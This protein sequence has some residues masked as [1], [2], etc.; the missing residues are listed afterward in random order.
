MFFEL[1]DIQRRHSAYWDVYNA[2]SYT[3]TPDN[4][5]SWNYQRGVMAGLLGCM[6]NETATIFRENGR[7]LLKHYERPA[8]LNQTWVFLKEAWKMSTL[9]NGLRNRLQYAT[10]MGV[11]DVANRIA[12]WRYFNAGYH[13]TQGQVETNVV[14]KILPSMAA[15][16]L[17]SWLGVPFEMA[18][19][20]FYADKTFP[21]ELQRGYTSYFNAL[22]RIPFEEGGYYLF[23]NTFPFIARNFF[24]T[25]TMFFSYDFLKDKLGGV[26]YRLTNNWPVDLTKFMAI[27]LTTY[28]S[29]VFSFFWGNTIR[30]AVD[31]WPK[32]KG[33]KCTFQGNYR[34]AA[35]WLWYHD[36]SSN[37]FPGFMN[38]YFWRQA[39]WMF[40]T[41]WTADTFGIFNYWRMDPYSGAGSNTWEDVFS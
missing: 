36:Y 30:E 14:R 26:T 9:R 1:D 34:K 17:T 3:P 12:V 33:G 25:L 22:R 5:Y 23:K 27:S 20:A 2:F 10:A 24:Q 38:N 40:L 29:C 28:L 35:T 6:V 31:F 41:L 19:M 39:P 4:T 8:N 21:K 15:A 18:R 32:E 11:F 37:Y 13:Q 7:L 16:G